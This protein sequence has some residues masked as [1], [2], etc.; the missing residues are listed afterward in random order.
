MFH[1]NPYSHEVSSIIFSEKQRKKSRLA[2]AAVVG[3]LRVNLFLL[4]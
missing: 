2:S 1:V 3:T 4:L